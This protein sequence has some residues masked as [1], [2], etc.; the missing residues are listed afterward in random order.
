MF[1]ASLGFNTSCILSLVCLS[2][3]TLEIRTNQE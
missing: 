1:I 3:N 2:K